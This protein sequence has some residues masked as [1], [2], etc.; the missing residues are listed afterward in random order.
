MKKI[1]LT[2]AL[3]L[4]VSLTTFADGGGLFRRGDNTEESTGMMNRSPKA[5][6]LPGH[7]ETG[8]QPAPL[9]SG[10]LLLI[11]FGAAYALKKNKK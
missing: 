1:T 11:G 4:S 5:P 2:L 10:A 3:L 8:D 9:G 7:G 6:G